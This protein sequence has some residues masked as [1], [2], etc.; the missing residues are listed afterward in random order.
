MAQHD[1]QIGSF[2][3]VGDDDAVEVIEGFDV[4]GDGHVSVFLTLEGLRIGNRRNWSDVVA[5]GIFRTS[6][7]GNGLIRGGTETAFCWHGTDW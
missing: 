5:G 3:V 2:A 6:V 7:P 1:E 4:C